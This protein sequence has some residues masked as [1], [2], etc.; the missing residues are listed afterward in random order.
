MT[1]AGARKRHHHTVSRNMK[2]EHLHI[3]SQ[4][5]KLNLVRHFVFEAALRF[6]F[7]EE[8][9]SK[10]MLAVDEACTNVIKHSYEFA[11]SKEIELE[12]LTGDRRFEVVIMH[13]G[14]PFDPDSVKTPDMQK[15]L[16]QF[17]RGGLGIATHIHQKAHRRWN[18]LAGG[19]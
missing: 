4:T 19:A 18:R 15:Y 14:K 5:G 9:A 10:I 17:R 6:G 16:S 3:L 11:P 7:D 1:A 12:I 2:P 13:K 8:S